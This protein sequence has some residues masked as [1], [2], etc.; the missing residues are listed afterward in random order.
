MENIIFW[1]KIKSLEKEKLNL[2][3]II[4]DLRTEIENIRNKNKKSAHKRIRKNR[5]IGPGF[6]MSRENQED[7]LQN[8]NEKLKLENRKLKKLISNATK[9]IASNMYAEF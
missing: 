7:I 6:D 9:S 8:E 5:W 2:V 1:E 3:D 4:E